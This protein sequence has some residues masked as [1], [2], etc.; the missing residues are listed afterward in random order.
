MA[1][2]ELN[3]KQKNFLFN[4]SAN[5]CKYCYWIEENKIK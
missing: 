2:D 5:L 4:K 1:V 3:E